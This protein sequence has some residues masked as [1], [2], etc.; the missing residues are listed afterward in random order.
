MDALQLMALWIIKE[1]KDNNRIYFTDFEQFGINA[2]YVARNAK[3]I[4]HIIWRQR[5]VFDVKA[6]DDAFDIQLY[7]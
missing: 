3:K 2:E 1:G 5:N 6:T 7:S 4:C